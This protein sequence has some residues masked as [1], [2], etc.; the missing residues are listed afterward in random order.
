MWTQVQ[1]LGMGDHPGNSGCMLQC[2]VYSI[3][4]TLET[5]DCDPQVMV[6]GRG[7]TVETVDV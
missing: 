5:M 4:I 1:G 3:G 6:L 2:T 7:I